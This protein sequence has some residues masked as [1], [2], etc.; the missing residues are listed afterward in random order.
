MKPFL[1]FCFLVGFFGCSSSEQSI[2][3]IHDT[4]RP[5][6]ERLIAEAD[7]V[8][9][10]TSFDLTRLAYREI[11]PPS[12]NTML[13]FVH[14]TAAQSKLYLPLADTLR[15][16]GIATALIDLR[17]HGLSD[18]RR[19]DAKNI[20]AL[21]RDLKLFLDT[22][23]SKYPNKKIVLGGH[24]LGAG[25]CLKYISFFYDRP[26]L[27]RPPDGLILMSGG[28]SPHP[29]RP[30][31]LRPQT[32]ES[33]GAFIKVHFLQSLLLIPD[34]LLDF[35]PTA[36]EILLPKDSLVQYAVT[37]NLLTT[38][39]AL[40]FFLAAFPA[41]IME[42]YRNIDFPTLLLI[43]RHDELLPVA[44]A[45]YTLSCLRTKHKSLIVLD[46]NHINIIWRSA[47]AIATWLSSL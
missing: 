3:S 19:G 34:L 7:C 43:G 35:H 28:F 33:Q 21:A 22:L 23:R 42:A 27:Y 26:S 12:F 31:R 30:L 45:E 5:I 14:G 16:Y 44:D 13:V 4:D 40:T 15:Q 32:P 20:T 37:K 9:Y 17:G 8:H 36:F 29:S 41:D 38:H 25:A 2:F 46:A 24:S 39:Y 10:F 18:G 47:S 1:L 11:L 6:Y